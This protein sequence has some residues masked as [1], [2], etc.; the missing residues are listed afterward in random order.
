MLNCWWVNLPI[1]FYLCQGDFVGL[2]WFSPF[3]PNRLCPISTALR[4]IAAGF[5]ITSVPVL[6]VFSG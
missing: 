2:A 4:P 6:G 3:G 1:R 5:L